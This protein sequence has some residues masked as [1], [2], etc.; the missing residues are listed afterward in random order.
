LFGF[1]V[2]YLDRYGFCLSVPHLKD[3]NGYFAILDVIGLCLTMH[4]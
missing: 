2:F 4:L 1:Y 3:F